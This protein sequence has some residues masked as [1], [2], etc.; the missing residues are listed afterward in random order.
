MSNNKSIFY[1]YIKLFNIATTLIGLFF[2]INLLTRR[3]ILFQNYNNLS[4]VYQWYFIFVFIGLL[5]LFVC[6]YS[7]VSFRYA[8][9]DAIILNGGLFMA[10]V[11][12]NFVRDTLFDVS[13]FSVNPIL[14]SILLLLIIISIIVYIYVQGFMAKTVG[15]RKHELLTAFSSSTFIFSF[16]LV[17]F[18]IKVFRHVNFFEQMS[19]VTKLFII[20]GT[21]VAFLGIFLNIRIVWLGKRFSKS[22]AI[23]LVFF[24]IFLILCFLFELIFFIDIPKFIWE[25]LLI[26]TILYSIII[27]ST[28]VLNEIRVSIGGLLWGIVHLPML[29]YFYSLVLIS[30]GFSYVK[31]VSIIRSNLEYILRGVWSVI[32]ALLSTIMLH[33]LVNKNK[34]TKISINDVDFNLLIDT[35]SIDQKT[36]EKIVENRPFRSWNEIAN[37]KGIGKKRLEYLKDNF[38]IE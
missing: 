17:F 26:G 3:P 1:R 33:F 22:L 37:I 35:I 12:G 28:I 18:F 15:E 7:I 16:F 19:L 38:G 4:I 11:I 24:S 21:I 5:I 34:R 13:I 8:I 20:H 23:S 29:S 32:G 36:A 27:S 30:Y 14:Y 25:C 9:T 10:F 31:I 6:M 2:I